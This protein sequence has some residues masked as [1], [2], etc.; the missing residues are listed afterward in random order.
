MNLDEL[1]SVQEAERRKDS[2]QH[3]RDD[4]YEA[5][6]AYISDLKSSRDRRAE[7]VDHPFSDEQVRQLSDEIETAEDIVESLYERRVGKVVKLSSFAAADMPVEEEGMTSQEHELFCDLVDRIKHNKAAV[8]DVLAGERKTAHDSNKQHSQATPSNSESEST[9]FS[10]TAPSTDSVLAD[11]MSSAGETAVASSEIVDENDKSDLATQT[12]PTAPNTVST[13]A[14]DPHPDSGSASASSDPDSGSASA[15]SD[16]DS[17]SVS[18]SSDPDSGSVSASSN[19]DSSQGPTDQRHT[20]VTPDTAHD[21]V[22]PDVPVDDKSSSN[23]TNADRP[24]GNSELDQGPK[25]DTAVSDGGSANV[26]A[27]ADQRRMIRI[28]EDVGSILGVDERE[29]T[30]RAD[31]VVQ[32]PAM[33]ATPLLD[34]NAAEPID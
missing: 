8:L 16:P 30:L 6:A 4:F 17:G 9:P 26:A 15:S 21:G 19:V 2:L 7:A 33:N 12:G 3:L 20:P 5:V 28:T 32:L 14:P 1:R 25:S 31:D 24:A 13:A 29:Y 11:A 10:G 27:D 34:R 18:A 22:P 23:Q